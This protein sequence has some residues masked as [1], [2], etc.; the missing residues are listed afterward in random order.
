MTELPGY[1]GVDIVPDAIEVATK[2][3]PGRRYM[4]ADICKDELPIVEA[5]ICRDAMQHMSLADGLAAVSNFRPTGAA[6]LLASTHRDTVNENVS[7][8]GYY[9]IN[10]EAEPFCF[11]EPY[12]AIP[13]GAWDG[14][15]RYPHKLLGIWPL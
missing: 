8:G 4:V 11:G 14:Q 5:I 6:W 1:V 15:N 12:L 9:Q 2:R 13:D 7:T 10:M 3:H